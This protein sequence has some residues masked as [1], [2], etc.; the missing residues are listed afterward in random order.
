MVNDLVLIFYFFISG[1]RGNLHDFK[2]SDLNL[3]KATIFLFN[4]IRYLRIPYPYCRSTTRYNVF[5]I[6]YTDSK[7]LK[8]GFVITE[9]IHNPL[10][11]NG[12][13]IRINGFE[14]VNN[15]LCISNSGAIIVSKPLCL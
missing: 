7:W 12:L 3:Q 6:H 13:S 1:L 9:Q 14:Y 8:N 11:H 10:L 5:T 15:R 4:T 2:T